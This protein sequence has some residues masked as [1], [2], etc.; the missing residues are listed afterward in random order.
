MKI[1]SLLLLFS[2]L[3]IGA[4]HKKGI[5]E[6]TDRNAPPPK[7][8]FVYPPRET[9]APDTATGRRLYAV[10]C[11]RCHDAPDVTKYTMERWDKILPTMLPRARMDNEQSLHIRSWILTQVAE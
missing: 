3:I 4:C 6:M 9:V 8:G 7:T 1:S 11:V 5:P 10:R 2:L